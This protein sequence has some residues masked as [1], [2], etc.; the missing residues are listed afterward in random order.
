M[1]PFYTSILNG[2]KDARR[3]KTVYVPV[4]SVSRKVRND[5]DRVE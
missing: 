4:L 5:A 2:S 1:M 3:S